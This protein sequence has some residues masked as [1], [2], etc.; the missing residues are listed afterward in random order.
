MV[1]VPYASAATAWAP[2]TRKIRFAPPIF[3]AASVLLLNKVDLLAHVDFDLVRCLNDVR[4][5]HADLPVL[6][7]SARSGAGFATWLNWLR[8][9]CAALRR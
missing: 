1:S 5:V 2:P 7:L 6:Q 8:Q 3:A 4:R 9:R